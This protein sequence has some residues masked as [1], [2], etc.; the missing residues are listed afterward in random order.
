M[1]EEQ[2]DHL[3]ERYSASLTDAEAFDELT[4]EL[5]ERLRAYAVRGLHIRARARLLRGAVFVLGSLAAVACIVWLLLP[6]EAMLSL[7]TVAGD[8]DSL[9]TRAGVAPIQDRFWIGAVVERPCWIHIVQRT[10]AGDLIAARPSASSDDY[11]VHVSD[12]V[13]L[14]SFRVIE[15]NAPSEAGRLTHVLIV[16]APQALSGEML[17]TVFPEQLAPDKSEAEVEAKLDELVRSLRQKHGWEV[18]HRKIDSNLP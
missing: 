11:G 3:L 10:A 5:R 9:F 8:P 1:E 14:G 17:D 15:P 6:R 12:R 16:A 7:V 13:Q 4:P 18:R 2:L